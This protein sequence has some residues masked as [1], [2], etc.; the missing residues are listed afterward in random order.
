[1]HLEHVPG[2]SLTALHL[3]Q[4]YLGELAAVFEVAVA[5][6]ADEIPAEP[7]WANM[8]VAINPRQATIRINF[9]IMVKFYWLLFM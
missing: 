2:L 6:G 5:A 7:F 8:V 3:G 4:M 9:F 1:L